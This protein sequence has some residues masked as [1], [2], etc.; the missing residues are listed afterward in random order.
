MQASQAA[1]KNIQAI[2]KISGKTSVK[3]IRPTICVQEPESFCE[4]KAVP[5]TPLYNPSS[6]KVPKREVYS[7]AL[8]A[9][10]RTATK[11]KVAAPIPDSQLS[12]TYGMQ[13]DKI[14]LHDYPATTDC[15][16]GPGTAEFGSPAEKLTKE[17]KRLRGSDSAGECEPS[18][19]GEE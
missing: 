7:S 6:N 15:Q 4:A 16:N 2:G 10:V 5:N 13:D 3:K 19:S 14:P 1:G 17:R 18:D 12:D 8:V 9:A 11:T